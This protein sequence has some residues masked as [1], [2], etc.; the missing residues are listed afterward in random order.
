VTSDTGDS[1]SFFGPLPSQGSIVIVT[2]TSPGTYPYHCAI[3][4]TRMMGVVTVTS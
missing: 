1:L 2:F 4:P 3:H